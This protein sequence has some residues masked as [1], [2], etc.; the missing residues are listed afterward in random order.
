M[1]WLEVDGHEQELDCS[2]PSWA[3]CL[4][5]FADAVQGWTL[6]PR[7]SSRGTLLCGQLNGSAFVFLGLF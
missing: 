5:R 1:S 3:I 4:P 7:A 6:L 2:S